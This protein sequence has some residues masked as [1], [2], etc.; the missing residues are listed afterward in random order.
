MTS[1]AT[2][3]ETLPGYEPDAPQ[4]EIVVPVF[5]EQAALAGSI[6]RLHR[7]LLTSGFPFSWRIV[8]AD[9]ASTDGTLAIAAGSPTSSRAC[10]RC[11]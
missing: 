9:N 11:T 5:N 7:Y 1:F 8:I 3:P 6:G 4:V 2:T 10:E